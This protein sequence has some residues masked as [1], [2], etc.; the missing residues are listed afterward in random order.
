MVRPVVRKGMSIRVGPFLFS[1]HADPLHPFESVRDFLPGASLWHNW[2]VQTEGQRLELRRN[3]NYDRQDR[4][5][6]GG[7]PC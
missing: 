1:P 6:D 7:S 4:S 2:K 3:D 5:S